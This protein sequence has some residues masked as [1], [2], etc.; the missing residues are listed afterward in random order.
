LELQVAK[1]I[2]GISSKALNKLFTYKI[3]TDLLN[4]I[5]VGSVVLVPFG[6]GN[7]EKSA[8]VVDI[9]VLSE[10]PNYEIKTI[11]RI[12]TNVSV[13]HELIQ[14]A[15]WMHNRYQCTIT[16][17]LQLMLPKDINVSMLTRKTMVVQYSKI[18]QLQGYLKKI[19]TNGRLKKR[20]DILSF[21]NSVIIHS[22][23]K[24]TYFFTERDILEQFNTTSSVIASIEKLGLIERRDEIYER[25][26]RGLD[27]DKE[28]DHLRLTAEQEAVCNTISSKLSSYETYLL[29]GI[30]GSGKTEVYIQLIDQVVKKGKSAIVLIPE[31]GLTPQTIQRFQKRFGNI[32]GVM[33]SRLNLGERYEQWQKAKNGDVKI[34]IGARSA[35]FTPFDNL[36]MII[37]DEE[38]EHTYKSETTPRYHAREIA[39]KR[40]LSCNCPVILGSATPLV[41]SYYKAKNN[42]YK[43]LT[44]NN[45]A[46]KNANKDVM[47]IDMRQELEAGN[48]SILS[49]SLYNAIDSALARKEQIILFINR[50]GYANA[51]SCRSCGFVYKCQR[52][53]VSMTYHKS[54]GRMIC[55]LCGES[56]ILQRTCPKCGSKYIKAFG[57][58]TQKIER[59]VKES[60]PN[61][62]VLRMD[63]DTTG[64]KH[65]HEEILTKFRKRE[66]D[67]LIGT[68]M[69]A[70]GHD[71]HHVTV[72]GV[73]A[74]DLSLNVDDFR[75]SEKT[76]QLITQVIGRTGRGELKGQAY[77]QTYQ[78]D[79]YSIT[80]AL[81]E[82]YEG[83]YKEEI[84]YRKIMVYPPFCQMLHIMTSSENIY[85]GMDFLQECSQYIEG[86]YQQSEDTVFAILG[87]AKA[88]IGKIKGLYRHRLIVK[89]TSYK[90]LTLV[91][92]QLYNIK[93]N[94]TKYKKL[95]LS[96]DLNPMSFM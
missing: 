55:H 62:N 54:N 68:Q 9:G 41:D 94:N 74:A 63:Q 60:F 32:I 73:L 91:M 10:E 72:V 7:K 21:I 36:G 43:L 40:G 90:K 52:C 56:L 96:M 86:Q 35:I 14:L 28:E 24:D 1:V 76:F 64:R 92:K 12:E 65:G 23:K 51:V 2:I 22:E 16:D 26:I 8:Y 78:P 6:K 11:V 34:M 45:R 82:D 17:A 66:A 25:K 3:P 33:H 88:S 13:L 39:I 53:D 15:Y 83:F 18:D 30:T 5:E 70:K 46:I 61:A 75:G 37:L 80:Y 71:F 47:L 69:I 85:D 49:R 77:I 31:I 20:Y 59:I 50:R 93:D 57:A 42:Q 29:H 38:H 79:H 81:D 84:L 44:L 67:I 87:P 4:Q 48:T 19:E 58:G 89:G 95:R 27:V